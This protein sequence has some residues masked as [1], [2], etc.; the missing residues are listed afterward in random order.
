MTLTPRPFY[1]PPFAAFLFSF[2]PSLCGTCCGFFSVRSLLIMLS[3]AFY[4]VFGLFS[5]FAVINSSAITTYTDATCKKSFNNLDV[6]NG[7]P[8]GVCTPTKI[9]GG[10]HAFQIAKLDPGCAG[11]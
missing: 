11:G 6:I 1:Q 8:D 2:P 5:L 7:Y 9:V 4:V 10:L 3:S